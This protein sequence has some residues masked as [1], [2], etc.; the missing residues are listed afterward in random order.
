MPAARL[1]RVM[2]T[3]LVGYW[4]LLAGSGAIGAGATA[5]IGW[6]VRRYRRSASRELQPFRSYV[7]GSLRLAVRRLLNP[8]LVRRIALRGYAD[9]AFRGSVRQMRVPTSRDPRSVDL[10]RAYVRLNLAGAPTRSITDAE[11]LAAGG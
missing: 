3:A 9:A 10:D 4:Q 1:V 11:L 5:L 7:A 2:V 6:L 8:A